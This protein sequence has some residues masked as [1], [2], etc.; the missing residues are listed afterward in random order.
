M[1][2]LRIKEFNN[3]LKENAITDIRQLNVTDI[4]ATQ[5]L[6][7]WLATY[8]G[9]I[10]IEDCKLVPVAKP[11]GYTTAKRSNFPFIGVD[12]DGNVSWFGLN[13][14][15]SVGW[16]NSSISKAFN[17][18]IEF[19][20]IVPEDPDI[21]QNRPDIHKNKNRG[22]GAFVNVDMLSRGKSIGYDNGKY[23]YPRHG[24]QYLTFDEI[25]A[26][27]VNVNRRKYTK[28][29]EEA[30]AETF[31]K[32]YNT[33]C[34]RINEL[35]E[36]FKEFTFNDFGTFDNVHFDDEDAL[37][38]SNK[39]DS[40]RSALRFY[41]DAVEDL[42]SAH[43]EIEKL[44]LKGSSRYHNVYDKLKRYFKSVEDN[45]NRAENKLEEVI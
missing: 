45:I 14:F 26:Y 41:A 2:K 5:A 42:R 33:I 44:Q 19:Y 20:Q 18:A 10:N 43:S 34:D 31:I 25:D 24:T 29:L 16:K 8:G 13:E 38:D 22:Q 3:F 17:R 40:Y 11:K 36:L 23:S 39:L 27:D 35:N 7:R 12:R 37:L 4:W 1:I 28:M 9:N 32:R 15:D 6:E 21:Y 30:G